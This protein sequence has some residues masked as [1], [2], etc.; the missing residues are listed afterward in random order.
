MPILPSDYQLTLTGRYANLIDWNAVFYYRCLT[1]VAPNAQLLGAAFDQD[2]LSAL[3]GWQTNSVLYTSLEIINL[4]D[5]TDFATLDPTTS[6]GSVNPAGNYSTLWDALGFTIYRGSR[7]FRNGHK[8]LPGYNEAF[9]DAAGNITDAPYA[10]LVNAFAAALF[11]PIADATDQFQ[12]MI[13]RR[14][15]QVNPN[16]PPPEHYVLV[17]L[18]VPTGVAFTGATTQ[19]SRKVR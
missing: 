9:V 18:G 14:T 15:L 10:G 12:L 19:N 13:P 11:N 4:A 16:P 3:A 1:M 7:N 17:D 2:V 5:D 8:R 6:G